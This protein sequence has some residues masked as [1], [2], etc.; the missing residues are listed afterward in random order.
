VIGVTDPYAYSGTSRAEPLLF[1]SSSSSEYNKNC[2]NE[3]E[4]TPFQTHYF[5]ENLV[6]PG[7]ETGPLDM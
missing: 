2:T 5:S 1:L 3:A 4:W 6:E 7:I